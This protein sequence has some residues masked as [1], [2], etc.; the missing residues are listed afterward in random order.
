MRWK[1]SAG[2][3]EA[4]LGQDGP[5][6]DNQHQTAFCIPIEDVAMSDTRADTIYAESQ[7]DLMKFKMLTQVQEELT[8]WAKRR[9]WIVVIVT[10][11]AGTFGI[12]TL[13]TNVIQEAVS[14][15][16]NDTVSRETKNIVQATQLQLDILNKAIDQSNSRLDGWI[17]KASQKMMDLDAATRNV[18]EQGAQA[19]QLS[20]DLANQ[21]VDLKASLKN[22]K[23]EADALTE[24]AKVRQAGYERLIFGAIKEAGDKL[25]LL[26]EDTEYQGKVSALLQDL[27]L[28]VA[29]APND[30]H[31]RNL[32]ADFKVKNQLLFAAHQEF[33]R[34]FNENQLHRVIIYVQRDGGDAGTMA[35]ETA[36]ASSDAEALAG[37]LRAV[38][39]QAE[40]WRPNAGTTVEALKSDLTREFG[41][42]EP[43]LGRYNAAL[44]SNAESQEEALQVK[45]TMESFTRFKEVPVVIRSL[46]PSSVHLE[47]VG[48]QAMKPESVLLLYFAFG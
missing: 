6:A 17:G 29:A 4:T 28:K 27:L 18:E 23:S 10:A 14:K 26:R 43:L 47:P 13:L 48:T 34:T 39:F 22:A 2:K 19:R 9:F 21:L 46:Q 5:P 1:S 37:A 15:N 41:G 24:Q 33:V 42:I 44:V 32:L 16:V 11:V 3:R 25:A 38:G 45:R 20:T 31:V 36:S 7:T 35:S 30:A 12:P 40:V 8:T